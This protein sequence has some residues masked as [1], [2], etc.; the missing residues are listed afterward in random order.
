MKYKRIIFISLLLSLIGLICLN[1]ISQELPFLMDFAQLKLEVTNTEVVDQISSYFGLDT[2]TLSAKEGD[3]IVVVTLKGIVPHPCRITIEPRDFS[4][5]CEEE[6]TK[7][8]GEKEVSLGFRVS[9]ATSG[10]TGESWGWLL[11]RSTFT[12]KP[13]PIILKMA[14]CLPEKITNFF[15]R[16]PVLAKGKTTISAQAGE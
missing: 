4:V 8:K 13:G 2:L 7:S 10:V 9:D 3:K 14:V 16:Y 5:I 1:T 11:T 15:V 12:G 6:T